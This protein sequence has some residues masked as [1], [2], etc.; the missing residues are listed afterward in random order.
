[1]GAVLGLEGS[2]VDHLEIASLFTSYLAVFRVRGAPPPLFVG[3]FALVFNSFLALARFGL[4]SQNQKQKQTKNDK[5][6][7]HN[8]PRHISM[9]NFR[10]FIL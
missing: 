8:S 1:M 7:R 4:L 3:V 5:T 9:D 2:G 10:A 6:R